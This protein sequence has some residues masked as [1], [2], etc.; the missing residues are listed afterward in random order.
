MNRPVA[1][2]YAKN[3]LAFALILAMACPVVLWGGEA[4]QDSSIRDL[5]AA[6]ARQDWRHAAEDLATSGDAAVEELTRAL[7]EHDPRK[8]IIQTRAVDILVAIGSERAMEALV[9]CLGDEDCNEHARAFAALG[10]ST[11]Q[12]DRV[13]KLLATRLQDE[14]PLVRWKSAEALGKSGVKQATVP[15]VRALNDENEQVRAAAAQALGEVHPER[16]PNALIEAFADESWLVRSSA[17]KAVLATGWPASRP[18]VDALTNESVPVRWQAAWALGQFKAAE[19]TTEL[20]GTLGDKDGTVR[21]EAAVA[22]TRLN[23]ESVVEPLLDILNNRNHIGR[24]E[25]IWV[26]GN[27]RSAKAVIPLRDLLADDEVNIR[28]WAAEAIRRIENPPPARQTDTHAPAGTLAECDFSVFPL[29][30]EQL[31]EL[32]QIAS[33]CRGTDG[34]EIVTITTADHQFALVPV[35][36]ENGAPLDYRQMSWGQGRQLGVDAPDFPTLAR[37]GLHSELELDWTR[38]ITGR[39]VGLIN[40]LARPGRS[41]GAGFLSHDEDIVSVLKGDNRLVKRLGLT[42]PQLARPLFHVWNLVLARNARTTRSNSV[43]LRYNRNTL[44]IKWEGSRGWQES[45]FRDEILGMYQ[46]EI[47]RPMSEP[48]RAL[49]ET[50]YPNLAPARMNDLV[51]RLSTI[52]TGEMVP[53]YINRYGFYEGHT[54]YRADPISIAWIFGIRD[55]AQIEKAFPGQLNQVLTAKFSQKHIDRFLVRSPVTD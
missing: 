34:T 38:T 36:V 44:L 5:V 52:H 40:E 51:E 6:L 17:R 9:E 49:L 25:A 43:H 2:T 23:A 37:D 45:L 50:K 24:R 53:Y 46:L 10:L 26:L 19:V 33:P 55:L 11:F 47:C 3:V 16:L 41:S 48:E 31:D 18:L 8:R 20:V 4:F 12:S 14:S 13:F 39:S 21:S 54:G 42:H 35:T 7:R 22:L 1:K 29:Y 30:P 28:E 27:L 15:L 32:P